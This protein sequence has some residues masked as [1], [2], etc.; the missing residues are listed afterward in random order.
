MRTL[1]TGEV[2]SPAPFEADTG[3]CGCTTPQVRRGCRWRCSAIG[4]LFL[5]LAPPTP[6]APAAEPGAAP[7]YPDHTITDNKDFEAELRQIR[8]EQV[9]FDREEY[10]LGVGAAAV[11]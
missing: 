6:A 5:A 8:K 10:L 4:K 1:L 3:R 7:L 2:I 11:P 9:S